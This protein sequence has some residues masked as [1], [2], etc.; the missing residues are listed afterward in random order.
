MHRGRTYAAWRSEEGEGDEKR[1]AAID[2][3]EDIGDDQEVELLGLAPGAEKSQAEKPAVASAGVI[4]S[5]SGT[6]LGARLGCGAL[7]LCVLIRRGKLKG[8]A[9]GYL[10]R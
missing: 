3:A 9:L 6:R 2:A 7:R 10:V 5:C 1:E 8:I 4:Q